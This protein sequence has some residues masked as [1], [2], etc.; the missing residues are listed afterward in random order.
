MDN[1]NVIFADTG[2]NPQIELRA[3]FD[4]FAVLDIAATNDGVRREAAAYLGHD[5]ARQLRDLLNEAYPTSASWSVDELPTPDEVYR[6]LDPEYG[7]RP[8]PLPHGVRQAERA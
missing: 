5:Q 8:T 4:N 2:A 6:L 7:E 3:D 1:I